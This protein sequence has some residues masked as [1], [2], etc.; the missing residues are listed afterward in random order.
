M[1]PR[2]EWVGEIVGHLEE[3]GNRA[4]GVRKRW[5]EGLG[6]FGGLVFGGVEP[7]EH[8]QIGGLKEQELNGEVVV[9][10]GGQGKEPGTFEVSYGKD[11]AQTKSVK[12]ENLRR[13]PQREFESVESAR[14][15][16]AALLKAYSTSD[17]KKEVESLRKT[18]A[19][20]PEAFGAAMRTLTLRL[21][22]PTLE[23]FGFR[24]DYAGQAQMWIG[25]F[26]FEHDEELQRL[27][28]ETDELL[29][30]E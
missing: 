26:A 14:E 7:G 19:G 15:A 6:A 17:A 3:H 18:F 25:M 12:R 20:N 30:L 2:P 29:K 21:S 16:Q 8:L 24:E 11:L 22:K 9:A 27:R 13:I 28:K 4:V 1:L 23:R 10:K 5:I